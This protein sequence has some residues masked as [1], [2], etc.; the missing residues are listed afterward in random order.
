LQEKCY[1]EIQ[2]MHERTELKTQISYQVCLERKSNAP[3]VTVQGAG[4]ETLLDLDKRYETRVNSWKHVVSRYSTARRFGTGVITDLFQAVTFGVAAYMA[5]L[6][7]L[8]V[9]SVLTIML[10]VNRAF[11]NISLLNNM[12][13][14]L[15]RAR[16][17]ASKYLAL[18]EM[19][20]DVV[21]IAN[22][23][24]ANFIRGTIEFR[25]V[26]FTYSQRSYIPRSTALQKAPANCKKIAL[27]Q[28]NIHIKAGERIAL[29]GRSGAGKSTTAL[30]LLRGQD[31]DVGEIEIDGVNLRDLDLEGYRKKVG[32]VEQDTWLFDDT[33]RYNISLGLDENRLLSDA[34]LDRLAKI[35]RIDQFKDDLVN[36]WDTW[37]G[38]NGVQLSG[39]QRQRIAIARALAKDPA[40]LIFDEATSSLD[41]ENEAYIKEAIDAAVKGRTAIYIAHRLSTIRD[42]DRIYVFDQN[43]IVEEGTHE[44]LMNTS[45][46]YKDLVSRQTILM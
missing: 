26:G 6:G 5:H 16:V 12:Q 43:T 42:A 33:L 35:C 9:G 15:M 30:L 40:I 22:P 45:T 4:K 8:E 7:K 44:K 27:H 39:G 31:P 19:T 29:V 37:I 34:E 25:N 28:V 36:G 13:R 14:S 41:A 38:E 21:E 3:V 17:R 32:V 1:E 10:W 46:I 20:S 24:S 11:A 2:G 18:L 23:V